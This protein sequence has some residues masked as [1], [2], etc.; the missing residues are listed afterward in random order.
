MVEERGEWDSGVDEVEEAVGVEMSIES[1]E[2][3]VAMMVGE[4]WK[5]LE[6]S[7]LGPR[8]EPRMGS[9]RRAEDSEV[10]MVVGQ[11]E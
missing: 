10:S 7:S 9:C 8:T 11:K 6:W 3:S 4:V 5:T 1:A 2:V